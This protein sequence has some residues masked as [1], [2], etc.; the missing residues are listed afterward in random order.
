MKKVPLLPNLILKLSLLHKAFE[1]LCAL[2]LFVQSGFVFWCLVWALT[3]FS[4]S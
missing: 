2:A 1:G 4:F 3:Q